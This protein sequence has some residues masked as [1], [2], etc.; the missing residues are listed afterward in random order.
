MSILESLYVAFFLMVIVFM[1]L[2]G[3]YLCVRL[4][5]LVLMKI[6]EKGR[7]E[8]ASDDNA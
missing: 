3:L 1:A 5:S 6:E 7:S 8:A 4:F 2:L